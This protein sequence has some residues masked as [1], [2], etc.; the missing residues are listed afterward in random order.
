MLILDIHKYTNI[1]NKSMEKILSS[2]VHS[3]S[4]TYLSKKL[5]PKIIIT[6]SKYLDN[7]EQEANCY[8]I[9]IESRYIY[10]ENNIKHNWLYILLAKSYWRVT[11]LTHACSR[12]QDDI[13][14]AQNTE[15]LVRSPFIKWPPKYQQNDSREYPNRRKLN[16]CE[17]A[18]RREDFA[19]ET[20]EKLHT[21][22]RFV[23]LRLS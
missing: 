21:T 2:V 15:S 22:T 18:E 16:D 14:L 4:I 17:P 5:N 1:L 11:E 6:I 3:L 13:L 10:Q 19:K 8:S 9:L 12:D 7:F 20:R 23:R